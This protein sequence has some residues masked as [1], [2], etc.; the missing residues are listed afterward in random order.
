MQIT[1]CGRTFHYME[2]KDVQMIYTVHNK[3]TPNFYINE[4]KNKHKDL[5]IYGY[6]IT[7]SNEFNGNKTLV[8]Y[9]LKGVLLTASANQL[10]KS[11]DISRIRY[12]D[13]DIVYVTNC[14]LLNE[15]KNIRCT[16]FTPGKQTK[17]TTYGNHECHLV[18][19]DCNREWSKLITNIVSDDRETFCYC[20]QRISFKG[21][22]AAYFYVNKFTYNGET[23]YKYGIAHN[24]IKRRTLFKNNNGLDSE[25]IIA[26]LF[27]NSLEA[28]DLEDMLKYTNLIN[29]MRHVKIKDGCTELTDEAGLKF[30][31]EE[32]T[33]M[34]KL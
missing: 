31:M 5:K 1:R 12:R 11:K 18:C 7:S 23:V 14:I 25:E 17:N 24:T 34:G 15:G 13:D 8:L 28:A 10:M 16:G 33:Y 4:I 20:A 26:V 29:H 22:C 3:K 19:D 27:E 6:N 2:P 9:E 30:I 32:L 21:K